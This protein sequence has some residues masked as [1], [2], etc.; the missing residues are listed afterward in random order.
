M[1]LTPMIISLEAALTSVTKVP[2]TAPPFILGS[3]SKSRQMLLAA[4]GATFEVVAPNID[5]KALGDRTRDPQGLVTLIANAKADAIGPC[6]EKVLLTG[7]QVVVYDGRIRE[8]PETLVQCRDFIASYSGQKCS[9][10][11]AVCLERNEKRVV[12]VH[13]AAVHFDVI[14]DAVID[15]LVEKDGAMLMQCAGGL[16]VEHEL[17]QPYVR[18]VSGGLDSIMGLSTAL[19]AE[20]LMSLDQ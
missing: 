14:P 4:T 7:D 1:I 9:T 8:K 2:A 16:M 13:E 10:V 6:S 18:D 19:V 12:G 15:E 3:S 20:L 5:E 11:G 17:I